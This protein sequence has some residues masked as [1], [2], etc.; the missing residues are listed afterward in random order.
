[1]KRE[2]IIERENKLNK[3]LEEFPNRYGKVIKTAFR[4]GWNLSH[5]YRR[6]KK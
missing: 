4:L 3:L 1:M 5:R 6:D 2:E